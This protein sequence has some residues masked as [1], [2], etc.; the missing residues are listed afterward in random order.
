[1]TVYLVFILNCD[2]VMVWVHPLVYFQQERYIFLHLSGCVAPSPCV[3]LLVLNTADCWVT[4]RKYLNTQK[5]EKPKWLW[6]AVG[7]RTSFSAASKTVCVNSITLNER[8]KMPLPICHAE[9][10]FFCGHFTT[11]ISLSKI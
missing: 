9:N 1:M 8:E 3:C 7:D 2:A 5:R 10:S 11:A 4:T 6:T